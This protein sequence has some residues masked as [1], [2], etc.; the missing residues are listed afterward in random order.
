MGKYSR[1]ATMAI[2]PSAVIGAGQY[3]VE[4][5]GSREWINVGV[6]MA[7]PAALSAGGSLL[8][9][10]IMAQKSIKTEKAF[11]ALTGET[12]LA[13]PFREHSELNETATDS[14]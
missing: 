7:F 13:K 10:S 1:A 2:A 11:E 8:H 4:S 6:S 5:T 12:I 14:L 3:Q 9:N